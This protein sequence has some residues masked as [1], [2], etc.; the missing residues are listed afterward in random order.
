MTDAIKHLEPYAPALTEVALRTSKIKRLRGEL[1]KE[2][3]DRR[4]FLAA[5]RDKGAP[6]E[7]LAKAADVSPVRVS[8]ILAGGAK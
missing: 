5:A 1:N 7:E 6:R 3:E 8:Q 2:L 4:G